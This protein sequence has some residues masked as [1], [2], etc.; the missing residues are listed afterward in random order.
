MRQERRPVKHALCVEARDAP[1]T[2]WRLVLPKR[3]GEWLL[4]SHPLDGRWRPLPAGATELLHGSPCR[5]C[6]HSRPAEASTN[7]QSWQSQRANRKDG[8]IDAVSRARPYAQ[9]RLVPLVGAHPCRPDTRLCRR[10]EPRARA[11]H[12]SR[13]H[14]NPQPRQVS[15]AAATS[16]AALATRPCA[17]PKPVSPCSKRH[18]QQCCWALEWPRQ[19][20][21]SCPSNQVRTLLS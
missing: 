15:I 9:I 12:S 4:G 7:I 2:V 1:M 8:P 19:S 20:T 17:K 14:L 13:H 16:M 21:S 5:E 11:S 10:T 3:R 6:H 18:C